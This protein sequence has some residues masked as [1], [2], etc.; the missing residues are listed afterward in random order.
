MGFY[1]EAHGIPDSELAL[2]CPMALYVLHKRQLAHM[3]RTDHLDHIDDSELA[4]ELMAIESDE[5]LD[6][7][8]RE[9]LIE[10][11]FSSVC[12]EVTFR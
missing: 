12:V 2:V 5:G 3:I 8:T 4:V 1:A 6:E 9:G 7:G 10:L 11:L